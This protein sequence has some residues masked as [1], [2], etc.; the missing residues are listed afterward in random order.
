MRAG[1]VLAFVAAV[2][3]M[4]PRIVSS[5]EQ[6]RDV[7]LV[8]RGMTYYLEGGNTPNPL[9]KF[10]A[11]ERVRV[12][13]RNE[14]RGMSHDFNIKSWNIATKILEGQGQDTVTFRVPD[15]SGT[16]IV[17]SCSPHTAMMNGFIVIE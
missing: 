2:S 7:T 11:G 9:L 6:L 10:T 4:P 5:R 17:Y 1:F 12:T 8:V 3:I 14:D 16:P 13:L 15:R